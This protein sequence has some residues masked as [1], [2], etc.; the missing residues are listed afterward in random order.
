MEAWDSLS[1]MGSF[2]TLRIWGAAV[3]FLSASLLAVGSNA[4]Q[5]IPVDHSF[6]RLH[7][8]RAGGGRFVDVRAG[9]TMA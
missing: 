5:N 7:L 2:G 9:S 6:M 4:Q 1:Q 3:R 8:G